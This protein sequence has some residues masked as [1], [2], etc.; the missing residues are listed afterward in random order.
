LSGGGESAESPEWEETN[1]LL[2]GADRR[3]IVLEAPEDAAATAGP[4]PSVVRCDACGLCYTSPRPTPA[5]MQRFYPEGYSPHR[6]EPHAKALKRKKWWA[7]WL[8]WGSPVRSALLRHEKGRLLDFGCGGGKFLAQMH[9]EGWQVLGV[10][11]SDSVVDRVKQALGLPALAGDLSAPELDGSSFDLVTMRQSL[12]HVHDPLEVLRQARRLLVP[13]GTLMVWVPN[14]D[15][16]PFRWFGPAWYGLDLPRHLAHFTP[17]TL[18][19]MVVEAGFQA[20]RL[21]M[22]RH[23]SWLQ[24]SARRARELG[25]CGPK[26]RWLAWRPVCR[27]VTRYAFVTRQSDCIALLATRPDD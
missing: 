17:S 24:R 8:G 4:R 7:G 9:A 10:D 23:S 5:A 1:C 19:R 26:S 18:R 15:S 3:S 20:E 2:C 14:I 27:L 6:L 13:G 25:R 12:E 22:V 16:L 21:W 11:I